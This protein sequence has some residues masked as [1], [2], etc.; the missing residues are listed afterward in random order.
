MFYIDPK[1]GN[2]LKTF[3]LPSPVYSIVV[4]GNGLL[5]VWPSSQASGSQAEINRL[6]TV[7]IA[8]GSETSSDALFQGNSILKLSPDGKSIFAAGD[9]TTG[10]PDCNKHHIGKIDKSAKEPRKV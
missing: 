7:D 10:L 6:I 9:Y 5:Y 4:P 2:L 8:T 1:D 3:R